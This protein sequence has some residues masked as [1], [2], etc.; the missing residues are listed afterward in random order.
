VVTVPPAV[1]PTVPPVPTPIPALNAQVIGFAQANQGQV[2]TS[3]EGTGCAALV[4]AALAA[5]GGI[6]QSQLGSTGP[7]SNHYVWGNLIY[8]R[9]TVA[10]YGA[11]GVL[12]DIQP[13]DIIQLDQYTE[14]DANGAW[15]LA[16]HHTAIVQSV[17]PNSGEIVVLQQNWNGNQAT[18][19]GVLNP[20]M[21]TSGVFTVYRPISAAAAA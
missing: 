6:P 17:D 20:A 8:Q 7:I 5:A 9:S 1:P 14:T 21:M 3:P 10:G 4:D 16:D 18:T 12:S 15:V 19:Q 2:V 11:A 13:G